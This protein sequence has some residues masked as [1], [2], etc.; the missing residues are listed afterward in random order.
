MRDL[1]QKQEIFCQEIIKGKSQRQ[2]YIKA[3]PNSAKWKENAIDSNASTLYK[4]TKVKQRLEELKKQTIG[5]S[6]DEAVEIRRTLIEEYNNII[7]ADIGDYYDIREDE[8]GRITLEITDIRKVDTRA[9]QE[10]S[11]V[12][13]RFRVKLYSKTDAM[14]A[15]QDLC[16]LNDTKIDTDVT[17]RIADDFEGMCD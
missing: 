1:T 10:I 7:H 14:K 3:Y 15:L 9:V 8:D 11:F 2:A 6:A 12:G 13:G 4:S 17:I 16:G 5:K